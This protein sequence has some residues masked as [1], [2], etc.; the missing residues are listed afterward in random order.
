MQKTTSRSLTVSTRLEP[1]TMRLIEDIAR[2]RGESRAAVMRDLADR[3]AYGYRIKRVRELVG[4][5]KG[6]HAAVVAATLHGKTVLAARYL[7]PRLAAR[8]R[9]LVI[10]PH[11]EYQ[12]GYEVLPLK[13]ERALPPS[14]NQLF[15]MFTLQSAWDDADKV[16]THFLED[17]RRITA[18]RISVQLDIVDPEAD[19]MIVSLL[20]KRLTQERWPSKWLVV[21]EEAARYDCLSLVS[22]GRHAG[23]RAILLSQF[24]LGEET[25]TN[26]N[27][28]LGAM[29]PR[30]A[31][32]IDPSVTF[33]LRELE[34][35][36]FVFETRKGRW[37]KFKLKLRSTAKKISKRRRKQAAG[38]S[39]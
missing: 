19:K 24:P 18:R 3:Y 28:I 8:R 10:D 20:L 31:E 4:E 36:E 1:G 12:R 6:I 11:W 7:I 22:R 15:Q 25:M 21:V 5:M 37:A 2:E 32:T 17:L 33:A 9:V 26:V 35:G 29:N 34:Q 13:Y 16:V 30:L 39:W 23:I 14:S 38:K 27:V